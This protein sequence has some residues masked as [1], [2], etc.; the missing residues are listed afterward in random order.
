MSKTV[1]F[2]ATL[3]LSLLQIYVYFQVFGNPFEAPTVIV[4]NGTLGSKPENWNPNDENSNATIKHIEVKHSYS[5][6]DVHSGSV[7]YENLNFLSED[8][9]EFW[10]YVKSLFE[11]TKRSRTEKNSLQEGY[12][13]LQNQI[14]NMINIS[15]GNSNEDKE[16]GITAWT[17]KSLWNLNLDLKNYWL[18]IISIVR[19]MKIRKD[20]ERYINE[21][22]MSLKQEV[23][24]LMNISRKQRD[25]K[26]KLLKRF[27]RQ[28]IKKLQNP[29]DC[30]KAKI[31]ICNVTNVCGFGC[32]THSLTNCLMQAFRYERTLVYNS[33]GWKY[34]DDGW[35]YAFQPLGKC[36]MSNAVTAIDQIGESEHKRVIKKRAMHAP[37]WLLWSVP[38][39]LSQI[40][41]PDH[42]QPFV[43]WISQFIAYV[44]RYQPW[45]ANN[46]DEISNKIFFKSPIAG[47]HVRRGDKVKKEA[48]RHEVEEYMFFVQIWFEQLLLKNKTIVPT[49]YLA[50]ED[51]R[52]LPEL[53]NKYPTYKFITQK[54][55]NVTRKRTDRYVEGGLEGIITDIHFLAKCD[56]LVCTLSSSVCR[57][58]YDIMTYR[59]IDASTQF[60]S[61]DTLYRFKRNFFAPWRAIHS[62]TPYNDGEMELL[63]EDEIKVSFD[64]HLP[65]NDGFLRGINKR[66]GKQG[67]FPAY[68]ARELLTRVNYPVFHDA[69][70]TS[71]NHGVIENIAI[72]VRSKRKKLNEIK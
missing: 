16:N 2:F 56:Y 67:K 57:T 59:N 52:V 68:K 4:D 35:E 48:V 40:V 21:G 29:E 49:V 26:I 55:L 47:I 30:A 45:L 41:L 63:K 18:Q 31:L 5:L 60:Q 22:Y 37:N 36:N 14:T 62:H 51:A 43:W 23:D 53:R 19:R 42:G 70:D 12:E 39:E 64:P 7:R 66:T 11:E 65:S 50:T 8:F 44:T 24:K 27:I 61:V 46:I 33:K 1:C 25:F 6:T 34:A 54:V 10:F 58:A 38:A 3:C 71:Y 20:A 69:N 15:K 13:I 72:G 9:E 17:Y 32:E 28:K